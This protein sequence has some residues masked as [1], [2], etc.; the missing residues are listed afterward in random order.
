MGK[1]LLFPTKPSNDEAGARAANE[2]AAYV[3]HDI[4]HLYS[5]GYDPISLLAGMVFVTGRLIGKLD[6]DASKIDGR[7]SVFALIS[8]YAD[9]EILN[10]R[11]KFMRDVEKKRLSTIHEKL[12]A[13]LLKAIEEHE[14]LGKDWDIF[15]VCG[16]RSEEEQ[17]KALRAKATKAVWPKSPHNQLKS[18][19]V[20][21]MGLR[22]GKLIQGKEAETCCKEIAVLMKKAATDLGIAIEWGGD[23]KFLDMPHYQLKNEWDAIKRDLKAMTKGATR[24]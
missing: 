8:K 17:I 12:Q 11:R 19:A 16:Y 13:V 22:D 4:N 24:P 21:L 5:R 2:V 23:W 7:E 1:V 3:L 14:K 10:N 6:P 18:L 15:I 9:E 20:D